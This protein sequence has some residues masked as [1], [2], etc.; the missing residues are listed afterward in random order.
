M[1][2]VEAAEQLIRAGADMNIPNNQGET[3]LC[4]LAWRLDNTLS[5]RGQTYTTDKITALI[6]LMLAKGATLNQADVNGNTILFG[7]RLPVVFNLLLSYTSGVVLNHK[8]KR[9]ETAILIAAESGWKQ[10][11]KLLVKAGANPYI[12]DERDMSASDFFGVE[13]W[14][15]VRQ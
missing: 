10:V 4:L 13:F 11:V 8:N 15:R 1:L 6:K 2:N 9:G 3:A 7:I 14:N 5:E 12:K